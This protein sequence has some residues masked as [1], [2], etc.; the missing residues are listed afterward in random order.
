M[1]IAYSGRSKPSALKIAQE[2]GFELVRSSSTPASINWGRVF[3]NTKLNPD[4]SNATN[5]RRM[6]ELF[7]EHG[8]PTP[9]IFTPLEIQM[10]LLNGIADNQ[11]HFVGRPDHHMKGRGFWHVRTWAELNKALRGTR[12]KKPA[13]HF[14]EYINAPREYR[15]HIFLDKSIRI[16][17]KAHTAF[18]E[19]MTIK[20]THDIT[21]VRNAAKKAVNALGLDFGAVD[22]LA[23]DNQAWVLEV[24]TAPGVGGSMPRV[25]AEQFNRWAER[26]Q[27]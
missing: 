14:M 23:D 10:I 20:P 15:V 13:T 24:N 25:Y 17:E 6:R 16:S 21:H 11:V 26:S 5:K 19:Y 1:K 4:T 8:V 2:G 7:R 27:A 22:I 3:A 9:R 12:R 18:H